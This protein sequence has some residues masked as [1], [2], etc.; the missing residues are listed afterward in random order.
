VARP[1]R[2]AAVFQKVNVMAEREE[3]RKIMEIAP[4][5]AADRPSHEVT[6][7]YDSQA[8]VC[9][10][11]ST[12]HSSIASVTNLFRTVGVEVL[13]RN[14]PGRFRM[15]SVMSFN[16]AASFGKSLNCRNL[17]RCPKTSRNA[18]K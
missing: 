12:C 18:T 13:V 10:A 4:G 3:S 9:F 14:F 2:I 11:H 5:H 1:P 17:S 6:Q 15:S 16:G 7:K 8:I